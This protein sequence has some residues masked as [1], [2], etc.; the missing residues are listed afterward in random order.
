[1]SLTPLYHFHPLPKY[2]DI[3]RVI[4][5]E[6]SPMHIQL[7]AGLEPET[8]GYRAQVTS[9]QAS[10]KLS[11]N[12]NVQKVIRLI[13]APKFGYYRLHYWQPFHSLDEMQICLNQAFSIPFQEIEIL[14]PKKRKI[15]T[16]IFIVQ[17]CIQVPTNI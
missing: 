3:S 10:L 9:H 17:R 2:L 14:S 12:L 1:M 15:T 13:L 5:A 4:T 6:S 7:A 11:E 8:F 16:K